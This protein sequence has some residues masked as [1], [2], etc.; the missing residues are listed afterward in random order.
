MDDEELNYIDCLPVVTPE[1]RQWLRHDSPNT[2]AIID[3]ANGHAL[4]A[5][6]AWNYC[7][8]AQPEPAAPAG[9][10]VLPDGS[11]FARASWPLPKNH[12]LYAPRGAWDSERDDFAETPRPIL[13]NA[14]REAVIAASRYAIRGATMCGQEQDFDPDA[15]VQNICY[16]LCGPA[17]GSV[18]PADA[19]PSVAPE[20]PTR[21]ALAEIVRLH[22]TSTYHCTR[23]WEAW[24]VGTMTEDDFEPAS[25]SDMAEEIA[26][27]ILAA[28]PPRA[29]AAKYSDLVSDGGMDPRNAAPADLDYHC[30]IKCESCGHK[31]YF[32]RRQL[33]DSHL[34]TP[35][36]TQPEPSTLTPEQRARLISSGP[37]AGRVRGV[38]PPPPLSGEDITSEYFASQLTTKDSVES[39]F[40][41]GVRWAEKAHGIGAGA[42][43]AADR[44]AQPIGETQSIQSR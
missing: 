4:A 3:W 28:H 12:W 38:P 37:N 17:N 25:E 36:A 22:L 9:V 16:A 8:P 44:A 34:S 43:V 13:T 26:D 41:A 39:V 40:A 1:E 11:A 7:A 15:L 33:E 19:A 14:Q 23:V 21:E 5:I 10:T 30:T 35:D 20:P 31:N 2:Q 18:L 27:A 6:A 32:T 24:H 42:V 29:P